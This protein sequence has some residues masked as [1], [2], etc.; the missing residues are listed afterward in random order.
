MYNSTFYSDSSVI[1]SFLG[2]ILGFFLFFIFIALIVGILI[3]IG[4]WNIFKKGGE[5][6]WKAIIPFYNTYTMCKLVGVNPYWVLIVVVGCLFTTVP[7]LN[8]VAGVASIYFTVLLNVSLAKAF[9]K[10]TGFAIGLIFLPYIFYPI[11]GLGKQEFIGANPMDDI[12]FKNIQSNPTNNQ[13]TVNSSI[14][15]VSVNEQNNE[16]P[17]NPISNSSEVGTLNNQAKVSKEK[18][19]CSNCGFEL[20]DED[21]FC[22]NCGTKKN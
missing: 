8:I 18:I 4:R 20:T 14:E 16:T 12:I 2:L 17:I 5:E 11:L 7:L 13:T 22:T 9:G 3:I 21:N 1:G 19:V 6:G 15:P 10:D